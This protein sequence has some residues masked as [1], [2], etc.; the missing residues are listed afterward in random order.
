MW[1]MLFVVTNKV[2]KDRVQPSSIWGAYYNMF[3]IIYK[4]T[5]FT[6]LICIVQRMD[7]KFDENCCTSG[8]WAASSIV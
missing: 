4:K 8:H 5:T 1:D 7:Q 3:H 2:T 6:K